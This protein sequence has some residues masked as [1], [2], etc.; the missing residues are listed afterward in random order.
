MGQGAKMSAFGDI[1]Y[2]S[3]LGSSSSLRCGCF[4]RIFAA[5]PL[6]GGVKNAN[7]AG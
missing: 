2:S 5:P 1:C 4:C 3:S 6:L 7:A